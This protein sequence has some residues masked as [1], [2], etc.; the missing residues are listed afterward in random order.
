MQSE[1]YVDRSVKTLRGMARR[2]WHPSRNIE[3]QKV[4]KAHEHDAN[5]SCD[6]HRMATNRVIT[7]TIITVLVLLIVAV[8]FSKFR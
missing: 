4:W 5:P 3:R 1:G 8:I 7:I 6:D 2:Y